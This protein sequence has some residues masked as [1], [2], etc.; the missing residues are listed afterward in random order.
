M[1]IKRRFLASSAALFLIAGTGI[2]LSSAAIADTGE[3]EPYVCQL[4]AWTP[5]HNFSTGNAWGQGGRSGCSNATGVTVLLREDKRS[6]PD[7]T[8]AEGYQRGTAIKFTVYG[9]ITKSNKGGTFYTET[10]SS[11]GA[12][13][14]SARVIFN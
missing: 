1:S 13:R 5:G 12:Q 8:L 3:I 6:M 14:Q 4:N 2:S 9:K 10:R 11:T 7:R